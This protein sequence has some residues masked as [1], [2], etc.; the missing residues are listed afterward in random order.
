[1]ACQAIPLLLLS[2]QT[3]KGISGLG[4][5][6]GWVDS[7]MV[8]SRV[9]P[10]PE[11]FWGT[12]SSASMRT[13]RA[14]SGLAPIMGFTDRVRQPFGSTLGGTG[15]FPTM[16]I[17]FPKIVPANSGSAP[18]VAARLNIRTTALL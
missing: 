6:R 10:F 12:H 9:I 13:V 8:T 17:L 11:V 3:E 5:V 14:I 2:R 15:C 1:M 16:Y 4:L 18:M 7:R